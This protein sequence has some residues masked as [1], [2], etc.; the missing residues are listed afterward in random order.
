MRV[1]LAERHADQHE[2]IAGGLEAQT[3]TASVA[4]VQRVVDRYAALRDGTDAKREG[5]R[6]ADKKVAELLAVRNVLSPA[7]ESTYRSH[8]AKARAIAPDLPDAPLADSQ[9]AYLE[10]AMEFH[11]SVTEWREIA[12][13]T[14]TRRDYQIA[15]GLASRRKA[16]K[17]GTSVEAD[18]D[19][20]GPMD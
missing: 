12:R 2:Y 15:L 10:A 3:G 5:T 18:D 11:I 1:V 9:K 6:A 19:S 7:I 4:V 14:I 16:S 17:S 8:L 13:Q 20:D